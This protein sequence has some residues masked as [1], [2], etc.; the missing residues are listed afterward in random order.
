M[1]NID[2]AFRMALEQRAF[3]IGQLT[4]RNNFFMVFQG[5]L[6]AGLV[7]SQGAASPMMNF[8]VCLAGMAISCFQACMA[9]GA[10]YWQIRWEAAVKRLELMLLE[11]MKDQPKVFQLFTADM[12][13]LT[14]A[15]QTRVRQINLAPARALDPLEVQKGFIQK[16]VN[17]DLKDSGRL[18]AF[19]I[20]QR[21]SVSKIPFW[22]GFVLFWIWFFIWINT[23][24]I[25]GKP[26]GAW[27]AGLAWWD[28][29]V[30]RFFSFVKA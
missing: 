20:S 4:N 2:A 13:H 16:L 1:G 19:A 27:I 22:V 23:F 11:E 15:E 17:E 25:L 26:L 5:V 9:G 24:A 8:F 6:L 14:S 30:F 18:I 3:E 29:E 10:K 12:K 28:A 7:Q 21:F